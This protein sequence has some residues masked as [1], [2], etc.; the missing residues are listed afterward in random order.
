MVRHQLRFLDILQVLVH[1]R[2]EFIVIGGVAAI[3][4][5]APV[6]TFDLDIMQQRST[7]NHERLLKAL[8]ELNARYRDP[9][10]RHIVP[11]RAKLEIRRISIKQPRV[12]ERSERHPG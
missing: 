7:E 1:H 4:E 9:A 12:S 6:S 5:G 8:G 10:G 11:D 3:L 2:V